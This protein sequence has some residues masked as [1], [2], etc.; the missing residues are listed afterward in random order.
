MWDLQ[1]QV[2][3]KQEIMELCYCLAIVILSLMGEW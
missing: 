3:V 2:I 1:F